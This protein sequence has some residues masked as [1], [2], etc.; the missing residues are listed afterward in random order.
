MITTLELA[1]IKM[2]FVVHY[3]MQRPWL[4]HGPNLKKHKHS[5]RPKKTQQFGVLN[6]WKERRGE[7][8]V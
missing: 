8:K 3:V 2:A 6:C 4:Y 5:S 7:E 1:S